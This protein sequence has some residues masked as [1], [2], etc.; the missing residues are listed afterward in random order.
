V[1]AALGC[2]P[3]RHIGKIVRLAND[4]RDERGTTREEILAALAG[5]TDPD[6]AIQKLEGLCSG[7]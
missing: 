3:G 2:R 5:L 6:E 1:L 7:N 4:L